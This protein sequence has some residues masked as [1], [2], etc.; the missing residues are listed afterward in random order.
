MAQVKFNRGLRDNIGSNTADDIAFIADSRTNWDSIYLGQL[1]VGTSLLGLMKPSKLKTKATDGA[2]SWTDVTIG[3]G[4]GNLSSVVITADMSGTSAITTCR[5]LVTATEAAS[6]TYTPGDNEMLTAKAVKTIVDASASAASMNTWYENGTFSISN[7]TWTATEQ[8]GQNHGNLTFTLPVTSTFNNATDNDHIPT[9]Q[10]VTDWFAA[11]AGG[12]RYIGTLDNTTAPAGTKPGDVFIASAAIST[13]GA[14]EGDMIVVNDSYTSGESFSSSNCDVFERNIDGAVTTA[15][16]LTAGQ[17]IVGNGDKT[18]ATLA[19]TAG[20]LLYSSA[21]N[22]V[23]DLPI[24]TAGQHLVVSSSKPAWEDTV[25]EVVT[26]GTTGDASFTV[27]PYKN[28][29]AQTVKTITIDNVANAAH[30]TSADTATDATNADYV[31]MADNATTGSDIPILVRGTVNSSKTGYY[32]VNYE[33]Q[34]TVTPSTNTLNATEVA[35]TQSS[36][37]INV[38]DTLTWHTLSLS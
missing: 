12:M 32:G 27:T 23:A 7:W 34:V 33:S 20:G 25:Y 22:T 37:T 3:T 38:F 6:D 8:G 17:L 5:K 19:T 28:G 26:D 29:V 36:T 1:L 15:V 30:A 24:G 35:L 9:T 10:A 31:K 11:F 4:T 13:L 21:A 16:T 18:I 14:E 2:T